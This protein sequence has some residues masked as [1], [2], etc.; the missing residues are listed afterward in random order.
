MDNSSRQKAILD[1]VA[2]GLSGLCLLHCLLLPFVV[3]VL[4]FLGQFGN[5]HFH[6]ELLLFVVPVS[7]IALGVGYRRHHRVAVL[8][9]GAVGLII[10]AVGGTY[11]HDAYGE[12]A[13]RAMTVTGSLILAFTH[14]K[15]FRLAK[16][17]LLLI[18][19]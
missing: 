9:F 14:F 7:V 12:M 16:K 8:V 6:A 18:S 5:N 4:P 13:D 19:Q 15:N 11:V 17:D 2:V 10:L 1:K 3:A